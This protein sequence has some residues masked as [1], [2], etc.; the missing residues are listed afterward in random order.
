MKRV[1]NLIQGRRHGPSFLA[2]QDRPKNP[3]QGFFTSLENSYYALSKSTRLNTKEITTT[4]GQQ[5]YCKHYRKDDQHLHHEPCTLLGPL[6]ETERIRKH[7]QEYTILTSAERMK[8]RPIFNRS[9]RKADVQPL[10]SIFPLRRHCNT[11]EISN[12]EDNHNCLL[13]QISDSGYANLA[14]FHQQDNKV[15]R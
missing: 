6:E 10:E 11:H 13:H 7:Q 4:Y 8:L 12:Q 14:E 15:I 2:A 3:Q 9:S 5:K 1:D